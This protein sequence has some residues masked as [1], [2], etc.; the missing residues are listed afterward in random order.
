MLERAQRAGIPVNLDPP[1]VGFSVAASPITTNAI[2]VS[3]FVRLA[4]A[5]ERLVEAQGFTCDLSG[6]VL[7]PIIADPDI[8]RREDFATYKR[9]SNGYFVGCNI[10]FSAWRRSSLRKRLQLA[11]L[12]FEQSVFAIPER[13]LTA[14]SKQELTCLIRAAEAGMAAARASPTSGPGL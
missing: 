11:A 9:S 4:E 14:V 2:D 1:K 8:Y 13:R 12:N 6:I 7:F 3:V 5:I 10:E